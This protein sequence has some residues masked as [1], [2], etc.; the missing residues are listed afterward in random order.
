MTRNFI[1][2]R[3]GNAWGRIRSKGKPAACL[4]PR[5]A[6]TPG[7]G[8]AATRV[9]GKRGWNQTSL[10]CTGYEAAVYLEAVADTSTKNFSVWKTSCKFFQKNF[11]GMNSEKFEWLSTNCRRSAAAAK[12]QDHRRAPWRK[13]EPSFILIVCPEQKFFPRPGEQSP[14]PSAPSNPIAAAVPG[15]TA[16]AGG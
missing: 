13:F 1:Q 11:P 16:S 6:R 4:A 14:C 5:D 8:R 12:D 7:A 3:R 15:R 9:V 2:S 10:L